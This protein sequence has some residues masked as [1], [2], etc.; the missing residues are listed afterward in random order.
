MENSFFQTMK[1]TFELAGITTFILLFIGIALG[2]FLSQTKS[3]FKPIIENK[4]YFI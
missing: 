3:K 4:D 1:L 2:Y